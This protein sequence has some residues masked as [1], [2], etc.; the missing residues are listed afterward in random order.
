M[1]RLQVVR[2]IEFGFCAD[3]PQRTFNTGY[4]REHELPR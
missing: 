3:K 1:S 4:F 2:T